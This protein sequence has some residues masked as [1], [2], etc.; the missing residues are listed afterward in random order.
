MSGGFFDYK[1]YYINDIV[2]EIQK[3]I[4]ENEEG[5]DTNEYFAGGYNPRQRK[6]FGYDT[7]KQDYIFDKPEGWQRYTNETIEIMK[8]AVSLCKQA[9]IYA[10][11]IDY[12]L[13]GDDGEDNFL[14]RIKEDLKEQNLPT[15]LPQHVKVEHT[16]R[17]YKNKQKK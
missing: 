9:S 7:E 15:E 2:D 1:Q 16:V 8:H 3:V 12:M 6:H 14:K 13:S 4:D 5:Y 11:R 10:H 17:Q